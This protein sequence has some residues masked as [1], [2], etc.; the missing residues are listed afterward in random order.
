MVL[1]KPFASSG[2]VQLSIYQFGRKDGNLRD[3]YSALYFSL[4][5]SAIRT[6]GLFIACYGILGIIIGSIETYLGVKFDMTEMKEKPKEI[7]LKV[8]KSSIV[9]SI[10]IVCGVSVYCY[11]VNE[12]TISI[13]GGAIILVSLGAIWK[14][15]K[16]VA[17]E[18]DKKQKMSENNK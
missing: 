9:V 14:P 1:S 16:T 4:E 8:I 13:I 15:T 12:L 10:V 3:N 18:Q 17:S 11:D 2:I 5:E 7:L 6:I